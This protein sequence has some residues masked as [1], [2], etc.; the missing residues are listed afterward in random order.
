MG[1]R[2][3]IRPVKTQWWVLAWLSVWSEVQTCI[4]PSGCHCH[5]LSLASAKSRLVLPF[6]YRLTRVVPDKGP[7]NGCVCVCVCVCVCDRRDTH[8]LECDLVSRRLRR[9]VDGDVTVHV[10]H[11]GG[12]VV[13]VAAEVAVY[14]MVADVMRQMAT[15]VCQLRADSLTQRAYEPARH[16]PITPHSLHYSVTGAVNYVLLADD[17]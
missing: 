8:L 4:W 3:G 6:W 16:L 13:A 12:A 5:S 11:A 15:Q 10:V 17:F 2:K 9:V 14:S 7:L 1:G